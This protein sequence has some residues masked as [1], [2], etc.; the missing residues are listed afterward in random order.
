[1]SNVISKDGTT[2]AYDK[3][4]NGPPLILVDGALCYRES[5][6]N[7]PLASE[8]K[9]H[10]TVFTYDRRRRG[11]ST[12]TPPYSVAREIEDI[13]ALI[14][15][16]SGEAFLYGIS[17]GAALALE[18]INAGLSVKKLALYEA[19]FIVDDSRDPVPE[20]YLDELRELPK[21]HRLHRHKKT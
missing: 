15:E 6:P 4:G 9:E 19:P 14:N 5:G 8:L 17:S 2:I 1:M 13:E 10:F 3:I 11:E 12:N 7:G 20:D 16:A 21:P 18:A